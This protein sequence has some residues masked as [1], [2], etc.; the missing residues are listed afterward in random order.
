MKKIKTP[1][2][3]ETFQGCNCQLFLQTGRD[4]TQLSTF[5]LGESEEREVLVA[6][7]EAF[8]SFIADV[9]AAKQVLEHL[10]SPGRAVQGDQVAKRTLRKRAVPDV[11]ARVGDERVVDL[12]QVAAVEFELQRVLGAGDRVFPV[13][14]PVEVP[15]DHGAETVLDVALCHSVLGEGKRTHEDGA[16]GAVEVVLV[17]RQLGGTVEGQEEDDVSLELKVAVGLVVE[18]ILHIV[19]LVLLLQHVVG[20]GH[21]EGMAP[22]EDLTVD[23]EVASANGHDDGL[24]K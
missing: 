7:C 24:P 17:V 15:G 5:S 4:T 23:V 6:E 22:D 14:H 12:H 20:E 13:H 18:L 2:I 8:E 9:V 19:S 10:P 16:G 11:G 21:V 1:F 3:L